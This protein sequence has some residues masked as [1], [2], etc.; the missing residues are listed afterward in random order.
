LH[1]FVAKVR[2]GCVVRHRCSPDG[3]CDCG[4]DAISLHDVR[5]LVNYL[6]VIS[7]SFDAIQPAGNIIART[8]MVIVPESQSYRN[9]SITEISLREHQGSQSVAESAS[10]PF[11]YYIYRHSVVAY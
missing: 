1:V 2:L 9:E 3:G 7:R 4:C 8:M 6:S 11:A 5:H 10:E